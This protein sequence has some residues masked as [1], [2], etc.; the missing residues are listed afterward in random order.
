ME[1]TEQQEEIRKEL[2]DAGTRAVLIIVDGN[3]VRFNYINIGRGEA[4]DHLGSVRDT[5]IKEIKP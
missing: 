2:A 3:K 5:L 4:I 1:L